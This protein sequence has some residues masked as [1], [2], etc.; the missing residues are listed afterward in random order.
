M[1]Q[2]PRE[3]RSESCEAYVQGKKTS[4]SEWCL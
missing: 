4:E 1:K 3:E 2:E